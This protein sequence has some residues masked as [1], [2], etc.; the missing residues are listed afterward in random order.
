MKKALVLLVILAGLTMANPVAAQLEKGRIELSFAATYMGVKESDRDLQ[1]AFNIAGRFGYFI[2]K[3]LEIEPEI[4]F[5]VYSE[6]F[7]LD[8]PGFILS[9]NLVYNLSTLKTKKV[10]PF[11]LAGGGWANS[12]H[13]F[14]QMNLGDVERD[15]T[16]LNLGLGSKFFL[17]R[18]V[19]F[20]F[21]YRYQRFF[22]EKRTDWLYTYDTSFSYHNFLFGFSIFL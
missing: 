3:E 1:T 6:D 16:L 14:N 20:R 11:F 15:Y 8:D 19:A 10:A 12:V 2:T 17:N 4:I 21:E 5:S 13:Y 7:D 18:S 22:G 9:A